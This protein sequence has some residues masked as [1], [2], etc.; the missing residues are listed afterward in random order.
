MTRTLDA[1]IG[2]LPLDQQREIEA[3]AVQLI[4]EEPTCARRVSSHKSG[5]PKRCIFRKTESRGLKRAATFCS[6]P[7]GPVE[8]LGGELG[9]SQSSPID[10]P[11][12]FPASKALGPNKRRGGAAARQGGCGHNTVVVC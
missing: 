8:A 3:R 5:S 6:R 2:G 10:A 4:E 11:S 1:V 9:L 7:L 12:L